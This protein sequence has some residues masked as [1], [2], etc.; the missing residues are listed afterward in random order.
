MKRRYDDITN[1]KTNDLQMSD[2]LLIHT[3]IH[4][5]IQCSLLLEER[6]KHA[7]RMFCKPSGAGGACAEPFYDI[8]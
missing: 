4:T 7:P 1:I 6:G 5:Y 3:Y 8:I 2:Y